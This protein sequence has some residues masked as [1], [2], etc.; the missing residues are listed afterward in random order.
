MTEPISR[1]HLIFSI[2]VAMSRGDD[3][4]LKKLQAQFKALP[5]LETKDQKINNSTESDER[6]EHPNDGTN[7]E[8]PKHEK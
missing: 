3:E 7:Q 1:E 4:E 6:E 2:K 5:K 8:P